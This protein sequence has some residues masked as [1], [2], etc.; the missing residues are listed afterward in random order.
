MDLY[1]CHKEVRA[2][3]IKRIHQCISPNQA[4]LELVNMSG[5]IE[6]KSVTTAWIKEKKAVVG[7]YFVNYLDSGRNY[8]SFS[9]ADTFEAEYRLDI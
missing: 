3:K 4:I 7:G 2:A 5:S 1:V 8:T 6:N 9:P